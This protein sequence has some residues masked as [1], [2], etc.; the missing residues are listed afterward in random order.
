MISFNPKNDLH[1][2]FDI[3]EKRIE[4]FGPNKKNIRL[5]S[6]DSIRMF[7][8]ILNKS[9]KLNSEKVNLFER[10][11]NSCNPRGFRENN[12]SIFYPDFHYKISVFENGIKKEYLTFNY[13]ISDGTNWVYT[14]EDERNK[15]FFEELWNE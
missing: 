15:K 14:V 3:C 8:N 13:L 9:K 7:S 4:Q 11:W 12:D 10:Q 2:K 6:T 1:L 5:G